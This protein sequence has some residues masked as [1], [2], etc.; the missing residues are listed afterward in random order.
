M[1]QKIVTKAK[2]S[3]KFENDILHVKQPKLITSPVKKDDELAAKEAENTPEA[4]RQTTTSPDEFSKQDNA[5]TSTPAKEE[6]KNNS[7]QINEQTEAKS[8]AE[9]KLPADGSSSSSRSF[10]ESESESTQEL[11]MFVPSSELVQE[12]HSDTIHLNLPVNK[13]RLDRTSGKGFTRNFLLQKNV[14][15]A[16]SEQSLKREFFM[17]NSQKYHSAGEKDN[18]LEAT[19]AEN[20]PAKGKPKNN[21][22]K[23]GEKTEAKSHGEKSPADESSSSSSSYDNLNHHP[24]Y[25]FSFF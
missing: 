7:P 1:W 6:P 23:T 16:K 2:I 5:D 22:S 14:T 17:L 9:Q 24:I 25:D 15:K 10:S 8:L 12:Q 3:A 18:E 20:T 4:K 11:E 19:G 13:G 21:S